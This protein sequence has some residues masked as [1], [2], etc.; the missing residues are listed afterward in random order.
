MWAIVASILLHVL[1]AVALPSFNFDSVKKI[2][3]VLKVELL[4]PKVPEPVQEIM[5]EPAKPEPIKQV[6]KA[7]PVTKPITKKVEALSP[8]KE[9]Y[10]PPPTAVIDTEPKVIAVEPKADSPTP[11]E[12]TPVVAEPVIK[13]KPEVSQVDID[14][15]IGEYGSVLGRAIAKYK[16]Y[17]KIAQMRGW[18]GECLLDIRMDGNG[19]VIS[20]KVRD[21]SGHEALDNQALEMVRKASPLPT[22]PEALRSRTFNITI[23]VSFKLE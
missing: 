6:V 1:L 13:A 17:P 10:T 21:S 8:V 15:A 5:P 7:E 9:E 23:P 18:Q 20:A 12:T 3:Q 2:P 19:N 4:A 16:S 22:P 11:V 14:N